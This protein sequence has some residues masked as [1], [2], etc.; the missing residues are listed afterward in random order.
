MESLKMVNSMEMVYC[1]LQM[2]ISFMESTSKIKRMAGVFNLE[3]TK[4]ILLAMSFRA[5]SLMA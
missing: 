5:I 2:E 1:P 4:L 3:E